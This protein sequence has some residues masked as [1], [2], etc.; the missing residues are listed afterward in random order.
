M[1]TAG[2]RT[3]HLLADGYKIEEN[4]RGQ[5]LNKNYWDPRK[6]LL[7]SGAGIISALLKCLGV[8]VG[9]AIVLLV[10]VINFSHKESRFQCFGEFTFKEHSPIDAPAYLKLREYR[11][12]VDLW[13]DSDGSMWLE[14]PKHRVSEYYSHITRH[15]TDRLVIYS[16]S[17]QGENAVGYYSKLS[18]NLKLSEPYWSF[19]GM[20]KKID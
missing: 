19:D 16:Y 11:W 18:N 14:I 8:L 15:D 3:C 13:G 10:I 4:I 5:G 12:W 2:K 17:R 20:C 9:V 6:I 1:S 7:S